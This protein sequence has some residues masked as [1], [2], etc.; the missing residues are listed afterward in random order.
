MSYFDGLARVYMIIYSCYMGISILLCLIFGLFVFKKLR[1]QIIHE[2]GKKSNTIGLA[3][4]E[5]HI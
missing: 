1:Q 3:C 2:N 4:H 5:D